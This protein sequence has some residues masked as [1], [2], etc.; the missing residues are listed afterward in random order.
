MLVICFLGFQ[1]K[2]N[3]RQEKKK[4]KL[5]LVHTKNPSKD[6]IRTGY[7]IFLTEMALKGQPEGASEI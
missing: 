6:L 3:S 4:L 2:K 1:G 7:A 5:W